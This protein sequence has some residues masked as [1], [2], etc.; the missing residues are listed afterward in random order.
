MNVSLCAE[1]SEFDRDGCTRG[2]E[3]SDLVSI[4]LLTIKEFSFNESSAFRS[5]ILLNR[6]S[7]KRIDKSRAELS[8][9]RQRLV[10][11]L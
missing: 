10:Q 1:R 11:T 3:C 9:A 8:K 7:N 5:S 6:K 2:T 4:T